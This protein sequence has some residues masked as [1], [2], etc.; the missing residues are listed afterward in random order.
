MGSSVHRN[1]RDVRRRSGGP[2]VGSCASW[3]QAC[4]DHPSRIVD[5]SGL[6]HSGVSPAVTSGG[7]HVPGVTGVSVRDRARP[8]LPDARR[9]PTRG[10]WDGASRRPWSP[11]RSGLPCNPGVNR[12]FRLSNSDPVIRRHCD[13]TSLSRAADRR[14]RRSA[15]F[16]G[17]SPKLANRVALEVFEDCQPSI[18]CP[19][20]P[21]AS[22]KRLQEER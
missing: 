7:V 12:R 13:G 14:N 3:R 20:G 5:Q 10:F 1:S 22:I 17:S 15:P 6:R 2:A 11:G 16:Q 19:L 21:T 8:W 18:P 9:P 4:R